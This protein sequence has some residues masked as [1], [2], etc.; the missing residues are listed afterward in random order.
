[1]TNSIRTDAAGQVIVEGDK[2]LAMR[3]GNL[4]HVGRIDS[5]TPTSCRVDIGHYS[6]RPQLYHTFL[7]VKI[8]DQS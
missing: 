6:G 5:F 4:N 2:V 1:M 7:V 3:K 8:W